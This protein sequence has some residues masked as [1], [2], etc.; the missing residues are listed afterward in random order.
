MWLREAQGLLEM[1]LPLRIRS[2]MPGHPRVEDRQAQG[3]DPEQGDVAEPQQQQADDLHDRRRE[4]EA[5]LR[6][7]KLAIGNPDC[8]GFVGA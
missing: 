5:N 7:G 1:L 8:E 4:H 6:E 2:P 3:A